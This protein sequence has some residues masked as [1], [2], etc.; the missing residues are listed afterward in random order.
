MSVEERARWLA[1]VYQQTYNKMEADDPRR[2]LISKFVVWLRK[3]NNL[4]TLAEIRAW[5]TE[6]GKN[7]TDDMQRINQVMLIGGALDEDSHQR[8]LDT[9]HDHALELQFFNSAIQAIAP[10]FK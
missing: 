6:G 4:T 2:P 7:L 9:L 5:L 8:N 1:N 10:L 3:C